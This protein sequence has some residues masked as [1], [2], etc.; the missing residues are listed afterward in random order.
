M[1]KININ[2]LAGKIDME[3]EH[4]L[5][6][7]CTKCESFVG[8]IDFNDKKSMKIFAKKGLCQNCQDGVVKFGI[9][10]FIHKFKDILDSKWTTR[11][12][13]KNG[14]L[15]ALGHCGEF[16]SNDP[17][18]QSIALEKIFEEYDLD[19]S[20]VNDGECLLYLQKTPKER[21]LS[22]L[23]DIRKKELRKY[24]N[25]QTPK[26]KIKIKAM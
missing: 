16:D 12:Y 23:N 1:K 24:A 26:S 14:G 20:L 11:A 10:F 17:T 7:R 25:N 5:I 4:I 19:V 3:E 18:P 21:I 13:K 15:C 2:L 22:A 9:D 8:S 6:G